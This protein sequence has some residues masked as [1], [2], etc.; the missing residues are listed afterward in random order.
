MTLHLVRRSLLVAS[1]ALPLIGRAETPLVPSALSGGNLAGRW[2]Y[3]SFINNPDVAEDFGK[4][5]LAAAVLEIPAYSGGEFR[6]TMTTANWQLRLT[7]SVQGERVTMRAFQASP[8][9]AGWIYDY[10]GWAVPQWKDATDQAETLVGSTLRV[11]DHDNLRGGI[12]KGGLTY[13]FVLVK[14]PQ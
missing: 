3:R 14:Q 1:A 4:L 12:S 11:V 7:G 6:G 2:V 8:N 13:S 10:L 5:R 9:T